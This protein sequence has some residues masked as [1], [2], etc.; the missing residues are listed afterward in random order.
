MRHYVYRDTNNQGKIILA[1]DARDILEADQRYQ[2]HIGSPTQQG[3]AVES[4]EC[5]IYNGRC[6]LPHSVN[7]DYLIQSAPDKRPKIQLSPPRISQVRLF[8]NITPKQYYNSCFYC[9]EDMSGWSGDH[10]NGAVKVKT[11]DHIT[12]KSRGGKLKV[13]C[14]KTCNMLKGSLKLEEY[15]VIVAF[16][17]GLIPLET[18]QQ[19]K[20]KG[21]EMVELDTD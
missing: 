1:C 12:P 15:R 2:Q 14:C 9:G 21:E 3:V 4:L 10:N 8:P 16:R 5:N 6:L 18:L 20:F 19:V 17:N 13:P 7:G 11:K